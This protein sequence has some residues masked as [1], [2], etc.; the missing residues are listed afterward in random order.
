MKFLKKLVWV[1]LLGS[2]L[3]LP[4][5][6]DGPA[7]IERTTVSGMPILLQRTNSNL[8]DVTLLLKSGSG[9]DGKK[10]G[11]A[12]LMNTLVYLKLLNAP[13]PLGSV[14][15]LTRPDFTEIR[16]QASAE[17]LKNVLA[18]LESLLT[19]P[20]YSYDIIM[21]LKQFLIADIKGMPAFNKTYFETNR[22]FYGINHP[23]NDY[24]EPEVVDSIT[25]HDVYRWYRQTYQP[26]NAIL[27]I[28]GGVKESLDQVA[29]VFSKML[30]ESV[31]RRLLIK[32]VIPEKNSLVNRED[33][34]GRIASIC[35][36]FGAPRIQDPEYPA[37]RIIAYY[38]EE[39]Q[40]YF[41]KLRIEEGL[42]YTAS[43]YYSYLERPQAPNMVFLTMTDPDDLHLVETKTLAITRELMEKGIEQSMI[44]QIAEAIENDGKSKIKAG[45][46]ASRRNVMSYYLQNQLVYDENLW[47]KLKQVT[48]A[49]IQKA[50]AKYLGHYVRVAYIPKEKP[51]SF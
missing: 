27:S 9:L 47:P 16:I 18:E 44:A 8:V 40:Y 7:P 17:N 10:K 13:E 6:A 3:A 42:M 19:K 21:D 22:H 28:A 26:G 12:E 2:I 24:L 51:A 45:T 48:T 11:T 20:L 41:E 36:G 34:N 35:M 1:V 37:F 49:D 32:P 46:G 31:D 30:S 39:Y 29:K 50:A 5:W 25:G 15:V 38:L 23:Y 4:V 14:N 33:Y 43:V